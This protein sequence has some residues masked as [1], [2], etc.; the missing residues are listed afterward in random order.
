MTPAE[1]AAYSGIGS[2][3]T[4][5][6]AGK[7]AGY[8]Y[9]AQAYAKKAQAKQAES[10]AKLTILRLTQN[11][12]DM[13]AKNAVMMASSGRSFGSPTVLNMRRA[14]QEKLQWDIDFTELS[15]EIGKSSGVQEAL[16]Y[17]SAAD[18]AKFGGITKGILSGFETYAKYKSVK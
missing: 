11:Y 17:E 7:A 18:M 9:E 4:S 14:D 1:A 13:A 16:G 6:Y 5:M 10:E 2:A 8:G 3:I 15:G 12:N